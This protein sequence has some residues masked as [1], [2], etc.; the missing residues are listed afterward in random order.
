MSL[1][2]WANGRVEIDGML[3][4]SKIRSCKCQRT[5]GYE[6]FGFGLYLDGIFDTMYFSCADQIFA[7]SSA[8]SSEERGGKRGRERKES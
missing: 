5:D 2:W 7:V 1:V 3:L 8:E 4:Y 6:M